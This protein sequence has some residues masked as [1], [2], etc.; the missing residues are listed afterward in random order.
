MYASLFLLENENSIELHVKNDGLIRSSIF[1]CHIRC[2]QQLGIPKMPYAGEFDAFFRS[3]DG[4]RSKYTCRILPACCIPLWLVY[5]GHSKP[6]PFACGGKGLGQFQ[7][8]R[9]PPGS[10]D[11]HRQAPGK[12]SSLSSTGIDLAAS[13][14]PAHFRQYN[15]T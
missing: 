2:R 4:P 14:V 12:P 3:M 13:G 6:L 9:A 5:R 10:V 7:L 8:R 15:Q 11:G 1:S